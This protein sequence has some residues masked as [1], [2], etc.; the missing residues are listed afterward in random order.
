MAH[1][2]R[3]VDYIGGGTAAAR[4]ATLDLTPG[5]VGLYFAT[6]TKAITIWVAAGWQNPVVA[7]SVSWGAI[8]GTLADQIDLKNALAG[9]IAE[10]PGDGKSY[11]RKDGDWVEYIAPSGVTNLSI[12]DRT[13]TALTV[14]SSTGDDAIVPAASVTLAG[15]ISAADQSKL[16]NIAAGATRNVNIA[17]PSATEQLFLTDMW[18]TGPG[19]YRPET[20]G[21]PNVLP[22]SAGFFSKT[23]DTWTYIQMSYG[24]QEVRF[25]SGQYSDIAANSYQKLVLNNG[26]Q[27]NFPTLKE[28]LQAMFDQGSGNYRNLGSTAYQYWPGVFSKIGN[29]FSFVAGNYAAAGGV[30]ISGLD[31]DI[32]AGTWKVATLGGGGGSSYT[33]KNVFN[34]FFQELTAMVGDEYT[35]VIL[36][37]AGS[38]D[39]TGSQ[40]TASIGTVP[41]V[42]FGLYVYKNGSL[43]GT[44]IVKATGGINKIGFTATTFVAGDVLKIRGEANATVKN[45]T[46]LFNMS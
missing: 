46:L 12:I 38:I 28:F 25:L 35:H 43:F 41:N 26:T 10:A 23:V 15:L 17:L 42:D 2:G 9:K 8:G 24:L 4:P 39:A 22:Y 19:W 18:N 3:L 31:T 7:A 37:Y 21:L 16:N 36:P 13:A 1:S 11:L 14:A 40:I 20:S 34:V 45:V 30:M 44:I 33:P 6:D 29:T 5:A 27:L 32:A